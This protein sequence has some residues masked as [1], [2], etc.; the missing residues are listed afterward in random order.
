[1]IIY[2]AKQGPELSSVQGQMSMLVGGHG[3]CIEMY[4][5]AIRYI[6]FMPTSVVVDH[7]TL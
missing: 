1:M 2:L 3:R 7:H 5:D 6:F 4:L